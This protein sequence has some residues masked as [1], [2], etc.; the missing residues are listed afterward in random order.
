MMNAG[1]ALFLAVLVCL[2][3]GCKPGN[4]EEDAQ[5]PQAC[6]EGVYSC[7]NQERV[8]CSGDGEW[9]FVES[10]TPKDCV[11]GVCQEA[12]DGDLDFD[13]LDPS[14][15][16]G[17]ELGASDRD[18]DLDSPPFDREDEDSLEDVLEYPEEGA[19]DEEISGE[20]EPMEENP[21]ENE[22]AEDQE[23]EEN[24]LDDYFSGANGREETAALVAPPVSYEDLKLCPWAEQWFGFEMTD[25]WSIRAM[26][27]YN[28]ALGGL[29]LKLYAE[30]HNGLTDFLATTQQHVN[31]AELVY[32]Q[33]SEGEY[34]LRVSG[35]GDS[36]RFDL[37]LDTSAVGFG[38]G[39]DLCFGAVALEIG[40]PISDDTNDAHDDDRPSCSYGLGPDK[41]YIYEL[42][43]P[44]VMTVSLWSDFDAVL[45]VR[46]DCLDQST[47]IRC[48]DEAPEGGVETL[49]LT[50]LNAG[51]YYIFVDGRRPS[52][53][54]SFTLEVQ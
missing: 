22:D 10:C 32:N 30:G 1:R 19:D 7:I 45:F 9:R 42:D 44:G 2:V 52:D 46:S 41:V 5:P 31:G 3:P 29:D 39:N 25:G 50:D 26:I 53:K 23:E 49:E 34:F 24:C 40:V 13:R 51:G 37:S 36:Q 16:D 43:F 54:G 11:N 15:S 6:E 38:E 4:N 14:D 18:L 20:D 27:Y 21:I 12:A 35:R 47:E 48:A 17:E 8:V 28:P 33:A